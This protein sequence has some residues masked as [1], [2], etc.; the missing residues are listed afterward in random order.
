ME[1]AHYTALHTQCLQLW[2]AYFIGVAHAPVMYLT[3]GRS[4]ETVA[5]ALEH[6][7]MES[8]HPSSRVLNPVSLHWIRALGVLGADDGIPRH[9]AARQSSFGR[10]GSMASNL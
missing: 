6:L 7:C 3:L 2:D 8:S 4:V 10:E 1:I 5:F 9:C